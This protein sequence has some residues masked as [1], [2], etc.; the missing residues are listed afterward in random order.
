[1]EAD[2]KRE[3]TEE[4]FKLVYPLWAPKFTDY[5]DSFFGNPSTPMKGELECVHE[6][7][8][9]IFENGQKVDRKDEKNMKTARKEQEAYQLY[10]EAFE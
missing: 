6:A 5:I 3:R 8:I 1:M 2:V 10:R 7:D 9:A 4:F